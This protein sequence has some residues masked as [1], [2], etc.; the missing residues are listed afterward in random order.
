[1]RASIDM[2]SCIDSLEP[3]FVA[4]SRG[5]TA[6]P[7]VISLDVAEHDGSVHVKAGHL[8]G[9]TH[10]AVKVAAGFP[11]NRVLGLP[12]SDGMVVVFDAETGA[13]AAFLMDHGYLT[14]LRTGAAGGVAARYLAPE[15]VSNVGVIGTGAQ[16]RY[17]LDAL[18]LVRPGFTRVRVWGRDAGRAAETVETLRIRP[19]LPAGCTYETADTVERAV[20]NAE[21]VI[22]CTASRAPLVRAE[23]LA[24]G[25]HVTAVGADEEDK[26]ELE[27][28]VIARSDLLVAD[29]RSQAARIGELHHALAAGLVDASKAVEL[30]E[31]VSGAERGRNG[32]E[33]LSVC[34]LTG[35]GVQDI[36]AANLVMERAGDR[37]ELVEI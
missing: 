29:S 12:T 32:P 4:Y 21:V 18:A 25:A 30:G 31:I 35:L 24:D 22:T 17:Q 20:E 8:I 36:V 34:D 33:E 11:K 14:D 27:T 37:G 5:A 10:F 26:R 16:A 9:A 23:W 1:M 6:L 19:G 28:E 7:A 15:V 2:R 3:A 13:P